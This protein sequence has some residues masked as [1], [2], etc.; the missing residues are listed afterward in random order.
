MS[1]L[2]STKEL[3]ARQQKAGKSIAEIHRSL[4]GKVKRDW[5]YKFAKGDIE[6]PSVNLIQQ[7][8][9]TLQKLES[10]AP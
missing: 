6:D 10:N 5:F 4:G 7:L 9:D 2:R 1:L 3:L 8:H